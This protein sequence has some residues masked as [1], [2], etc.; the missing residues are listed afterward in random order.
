M[1]RAPET[2]GGGR[3]V[4]ISTALFDGY[5]LE[6]AIGE[7]ARS[8]A[9]HVEPAFIK[10]YVDF[11][12]T[13]FSSGSARQLLSM[14]EAAGLGVHAV[15]AHMD[16]S[17]AEAVAMLD[18]RIGFAQDVG[19]RV[20]ITN[21]GP[22][23]GRD[24]IIETI[25][26]LQARLEGWGGMLAL[27]NPGH[28]MDDL[29]GNAAE[30]KAL[31]D[32]IESPHVRLNHDAGN[33]FTYSR[34]ALQ[35]TDDYRSAADA[36]GHVH[37]KDVRATPEGWSFCA[38]GFGDVDVASYLAAIPKTLPLSLELPLRLERPGRADPHRAT[39]PRSLAA[40]RG[41][42]AQ[43]LDFVSNQTI[44]PSSCNSEA[45]IVRGGS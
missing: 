15:S 10:G 16:L 30:G 31:I 35:P 4:S 42:L 27:E 33:V 9:P 37:L 25:L 38:I 43:S 22:R 8:G 32:V 44:A 36:V 14:I 1:A 26:A 45:Q 3:I 23:A 2:G 28:G 7:I 29:I 19:A 24:R 11:D 17:S 20:L 40:L 21:A 12:E 34:E 5:P 13:T 18:R 39:R 6:T 41:A